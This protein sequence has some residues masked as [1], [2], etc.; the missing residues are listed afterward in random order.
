M[1]KSVGVDLC[2][3]ELLREVAEVPGGFSHLLEFFNRV[4]TTQVI[5]PQWNWPV[6][7]ML[8]KV[9]HP[10]LA[11]DLRPIAMGSAV[12]KAF[13][14]LLLGRLSKGLAPTSAAQCAAPGR[15]TGDYLSALWKL[16]ELSREW[17][18][19]FAAA[20]LDLNKAFDCVSREKLLAKLRPMVSCEAEFVCW[21]GLLTNVV[22]I[23]QTPWGSS[24]LP[25]NSGI[26]QGAPE[27]PAMFAHLA[28]CALLEARDEFCWNDQPRVF[29]GLDQE[30]ALYMDDG[31]LW[32]PTVRL[33]Q[34]RV[35]DLQGV[36]LRYGL[37][38]N[39]SKCQLYCSPTC[40]GEHSMTIDGVV[41]RNAG[42]LDIMG[43]RMRVGMTV[44]ELVSPL[45]ARAREKFWELR[46]IL[47]AKGSVKARVRVMNRI[48]GATALWCISFIPPDKAAQSMLNTVQLQILVW[49]LRLG[50]RSAETWEDYRKRAFRGVRSVLHAAGGERWST[51]WATR[52]WRFAGHRV[53]GML[54]AVPVISSHFE[55]FRTLS[56]WRQEQQRPYKD[57]LRHRQHYPRITNLEMMMNKACG[58]CPWRT[59]AHDRH[60]WR[61]FEK[62]W[63]ELA[64]VP[65]ASGR[66]FSIRDL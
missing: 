3:A 39:L 35:Q 21:Q 20:K 46:H 49:M 11:R 47:Q 42:Y 8:P 29:D 12:S 1:G 16:M 14:K 36:L 17:G 24:S 56:W 62:G 52:Y 9:A 26:K 61:T 32:T 38:L 34:Q 6:L 60:K 43:L 48:I 5:P 50:K 55:D 19:G 22:G 37:T 41:L 2:S 13:S 65:W 25:M 64:D 53:R 28:E 18:Q 4:L 45:A 23:L 58:G 44:Y 7:V 15:Q 40:V 33:L 31:V 63:L 51:I 59:V 27:S 57:R 54:R 66:Q 30:E 10:E